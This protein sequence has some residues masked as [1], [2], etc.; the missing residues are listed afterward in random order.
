MGF[1][2]AP[3]FAPNC[4]ASGEGLE[5][6]VPGV[7]TSFIIVTRN[8][9]NE[10]LMMGRENIKVTITAIT[11][12]PNSLSPDAHST[13]SL[14]S[15]SDFNHL[16]SSF[17]RDLLGGSC[18]PVDTQSSG[19]SSAFAANGRDLLG[20]SISPFGRTSC[21]PFGVS[22]LS[23]ST[24]TLGTTSSSNG[25]SPQQRTVINHSLLDHNNGNVDA[26]CAVMTLCSL[27]ENTRWRTLCQRLEFCRSA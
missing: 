8:C 17:S 18:S 15:N 12:S 5:F 6:A 4:A 21:S 22:A 13:S 27:Q 25:S 2:T 16:L 3:A 1:L 10:E 19:V 9:F 23:T 20:G 11:A 26:H 7:N 14:Q 24:N